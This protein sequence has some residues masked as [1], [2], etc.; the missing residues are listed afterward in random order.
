[1]LVVTATQAL[2]LLH[3]PPAVR[4][5]SRDL[6]ADGALH[7]VRVGRRVDDAVLLRPHPGLV[8]EAR[9]HAAVEVDSLHAVLVRRRV[10]FGWLK[11]G[12]V[13]E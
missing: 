2:L 3:A 4:E 12:Q 7:R 8:A 1:M 10:R 9:L 11:S 5:E 6:A 13:G